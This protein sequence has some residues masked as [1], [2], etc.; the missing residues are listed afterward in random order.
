MR[1]RRNAVQGIGVHASS[2]G[3]IEP[4][5]RAEVSRGAVNAPDAVL[6]TWSPPERWRASRFW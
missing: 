3:D 2:F 4:A 5:V 1:L 6:V